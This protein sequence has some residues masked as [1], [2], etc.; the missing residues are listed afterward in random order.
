MSQFGKFHDFCR[1][2]TL[3]VCPLF[4]LTSDNSSIGT[5]EP[6]C[7]L[8]GFQVNGNPLRNLGSII[9]CGFALVAV[10][11]L[12]WR[13]ERK[14]AAVGRREMQIFLIMYGIVSIA[15]IFS[16]GG[17]I[18]NAIVLKWFSSIHVAAIATTCWMLLLNA[19]VG[20]Q[21]LDDG[22]LLSLSLFLVSG[23]TIFIGTGYIA[24]DTGFDYTGTFK[25]DA[26]FKNYGLYV[27]YLIFPI[28]CLAGYFILESILVLR[29]LGET[30]PM[31]LLAG[32]AVLF[33]IGQVFTFVISVHL[34]NAAD[35]RIDG[36]LFET[37]FTLLAVITLW[38]FWSSITEDTWIDEPLNPSM[39][40]AGYDT[41]RSGRFDSQYA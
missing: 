7:E 28:V 32:A 14:Q 34:C 27:L 19:I 3:P 2:S 36:A 12:L 11:Y 1:D 21:I 33:A 18:T 16:V 6:S 4:I 31:L 35:G 15:E 8:R 41:H 39:S 26:D 38:A 23:A 13:S 24:L 29:V 22:T 17:F 9:L 20:Y 37:L 25:P 10:T 5:F 40:D 30:R